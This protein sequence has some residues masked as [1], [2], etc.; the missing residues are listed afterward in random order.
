MFYNG[1][2]GYPSSQKR[3]VGQSFGAQVLPLQKTAREILGLA[4]CS[5]TRQTH[6]ACFLC[7][8]PQ[9]QVFF[10]SSLLSHTPRHSGTTGQSGT[11]TFYRITKCGRH[12]V[13]ITITWLL[14]NLVTP[15]ISFFMGVTSVTMSPLCQKCPELHHAMQSLTAAQVG[16]ECPS[17]PFLLARTKR[18]LCPRVVQ[19]EALP[20]LLSF[21]LGGVCTTSAGLFPHEWPIHLRYRPPIKPPKP[22]Q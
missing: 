13:G 17:P 18:C 16:A 15:M 2:E 20:S 3:T 5:P 8:N 6:F 19:A 4:L 11:A 7:C 21:L 12:C 10:S 1:H 9:C 22:P 14:S